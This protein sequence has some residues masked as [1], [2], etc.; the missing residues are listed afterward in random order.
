M[1][2]E[3]S[4]KILLADSHPVVSNSIKNLLRT[5]KEFSIVGDVSNSTDLFDKLCREDI[6]ILF[7]E[8][9]IPSGVFQDG[10]ALLERIHRLH[11]SVKVIVFTGVSD[12]AIIRAI[13]NMKV[14]GLLTKNCEL[15]EVLFSIKEVG[16]GKNYLGKNLTSFMREDRF[17]SVPE[18]AMLSPREGEI[19]R[20]FLSGMAMKDI[21]GKTH[22]S[23]KTV[24]NQKQSAFRKLGCRNNAEIFRLKFIAGYHPSSFPLTVAEQYINKTANAVSLH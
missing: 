2:N 11:P 10:G 15:D 16:S 9:I 18:L 22:R 4:Y 19:L 13:F 3:E 24:S 6:D 14:N 23:I 17:S 20:M 5:N 7:T 1:R 12:P 8:Y 21:A